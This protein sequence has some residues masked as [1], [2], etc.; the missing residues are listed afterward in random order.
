MARGAGCLNWARPDLW[1]AEVGNCPGLPDRGGLGLAYLLP[2]LSGAGASIASPCPVSTS[3]SS[4]RKCRT[5]YTS[6]H[7]SPV[8]LRAAYHRATGAAP[9]G[10]LVP[11]APAERSTRT[12][13]M[14]QH[15]TATVPPAPDHG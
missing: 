6:S 4:N 10:R 14:R 5:N 8:A 2:A 12:V 13:F 11:H 1:G 15:R 9:V 3:R 7:T